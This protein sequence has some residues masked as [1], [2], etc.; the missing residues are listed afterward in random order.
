MRSLEDIQAEIK[1]LP[2]VDTW[3]TK[4]E[5]RELPKILSD[6]EHIKAICSG[7][8]NGNTWLIV[9]TNKRVIFL[10]KGM[11]YGLKQMETPIEKINSIGHNEGL[12]MGEISIWDGASKMEI[13]NI[14]KATVLP[15]AKA[16]N[17]EIAAYKESLKPQNIS[18]QSSTADELI[19]LKGLLDAGIL[20]KE[21]F[22]AEKSKILS[23]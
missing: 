4:K 18:V 13:K 5:V 16:V 8:L 23:K 11:I 20:T 7:L 2:T 6:N 3:G 21:E 10:D 12:L 22:N 14:A 1:T 19:K 15:F 17:E 9:C